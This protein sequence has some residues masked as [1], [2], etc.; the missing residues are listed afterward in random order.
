MRVL[1]FIHHPYSAADVPVPIQEI[2]DHM[3]AGEPGTP[4][5]GAAYVP[6]LAVQSLKAAVSVW[7]PICTMR[8]ARR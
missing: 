7:E 6:T 3:T 1:Q 2:I 8:D 5:G 4:D